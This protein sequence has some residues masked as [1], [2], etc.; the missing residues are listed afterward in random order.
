MKTNDMLQAPVSRLLLRM[1]V[2]AATGLFFNTM[3]NVT[4][5]F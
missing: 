4:D 3:F 2:P 5:T 1:A